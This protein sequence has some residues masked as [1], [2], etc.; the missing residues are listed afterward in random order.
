MAAA[1]ST[2]HSTPSTA[3]IISDMTS[4]AVLASVGGE[5]EGEQEL[6]PGEDDDEDRD[7]D[8]ALAPPA[9]GSTWRMIAERAGAVDDRRLVELA[10]DLVD[11]GPHDQVPSETKKV[12]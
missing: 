5:D 3:P 1:N 8:H 10:R 9:A 7:R 12:A 11:E 4:G 2:P 6:V